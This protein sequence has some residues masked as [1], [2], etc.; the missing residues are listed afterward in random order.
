MR[1]KRTGERIDKVRASRDGHEF[2]EAWAAREALK[3]VMGN[4]GL[5]GIA[6]EGLAPGDYPSATSATVEIADLVLYYGGHPTFEDARSTV[7]VQIKYSKSQQET[8]YRASDAK[9]TI[10]KFAEAFRSHKKTH[11]KAKVEKKLTFELITNRPAY[12]DF[13]KAIEGLASGTVLR[14]EAKKQ[15]AQFTAATGFKAKELAQFAQRVTVTG[16]AGS[17]MHNKQRL[18]RSMVDW[19][20]APDAMARARLGNLKQLLRDKAGLAGQGKN[21]ITRI[22][23]L[24]AL[25]VQGPEDLFPCPESFPE[26]GVVVEREQLPVVAS[27]IPELRRPLLIHADGGAGKTVFLQSLAKLLGETHETVLFDCFG[28]GAYRA[29]DDARHLPKRGLIHIINNLAS[30]GLCDPLLPINQNVEEL[31]KA[32][33]VRLTQAVA[34]VRRWSG[35]KQLL[36][37]I[38]AIDNAAEHAN[39]TGQLSFPKLLLE[40]FHYNGPVA[41]VQLIV[42]CRTYRR[43]ISRGNIPCEEFEL[44]PF[45][46]TETENYL[47]DRIPEVTDTQIQVAFS[48]SEGNPRILEH[49][50]LG[51]RGLLDPSDVNLIITLNDLIEE[52]IQRALGEASKRGYKEAAINAFL[53]GLSVLPPPV[54]LDEYADAHG[55]DISAVKSFAADLAPLLE[56]TRHGLMFRDEPTETFV[57]NVYAANIDTLRL[58]AANLLQKQGTSVYAASTL[59][60]LLQKIDDGQ[61]LFEL[62]FD[63]RFPAAITSAVGKQNIRYARL[64][65]A[66]LH[67]ARKGDFDRLVHLLV[68]L[69]TLAAVNQRGTDYV[70][71]NPDLAV[72]SHD[73][74]AT[75]RLFETRTG[76]P[77]T[78]HARLAVA[79]ALA[80][81]LSDAY[82]HAVR[83]DEW[84][85]HFF[86]Q[87]DEYRRDKRGP[88]R[89]DIAAIP[90]CLVAQDRG[91]DAARLLDRWKDWYA[92]EVGEHVFTLLRQAEAMG[93]IPEQHIRRFLNSL[94]SQPGVLAAA[95]SSREF[96]NRSRR[97]LI[98]ILATACQETGKV[99]TSQDFQSE[100]SHVVEDG[101]LKAAA[102]AISLNMKPEAL[103]ILSA[104][105]LQRPGLWSLTDRYSSK[106]AFPFIACT[107]LRYAAEARRIPDHALLPEELFE[108]GAGVTDNSDGD[109]RARLMAE[110][111]RYFKSQQDTPDEKKGMSYDTKNR[112]ERFINERFQPLLEITLAFSTMVSSAAGKGDEAFVEL[113]GTWQKLRAKSDRYSDVHEFNPFF[114]ILGRE[115][116]IFALWARR[117]L[118][119]ASVKALVTKAAEDGIAPVSALIAITS[120]LSVRS[121]LHELAGTTAQKASSLIE[122][123]D[124][125]GQRASMFAQLSRSIMPA[126]IEETA[127]YFRSGLEQ[128]DAIGSGDYRFTNELLLFAGEL[129]GAEID[130]GDFHTLSNICELNMPSDEEKFPWLAFA[131]GMARV[132]GCR[133]LAKLGRWADRE[134]ISLD[135]T[136]LPYL[137]ALLKQDKM[138]P[139]IA[140]GLLRLS[141]PVELYECGTEHVAH[142]IAEKRYADA[143]Q[144]LTELISQFEHNHP[145]VF[146]ASTLKK[147]QEI[148][149][150][151]LGSDS[152]QIAYLSIAAPKFAKLRDDTNKNQQYGGVDD[153]EW[154]RK[155]KNQENANRRALQQ[156]AGET[157]PA[158]EESVS[159]AIDALNGMQ[160]VFDLKREFFANLRGRLKFAERSQ[161]VKIIANLASLDIYTK[162]GELKECKEKWGTSS[163][164]LDTVFRDL[165]IPLIQI[166]TDD[167]V[168]YD[169]FAGSQLQEVV[170]L[171]GRPIS[172]L[173]LE[174]IAIFS[175]ADSHVPAAVWMAFATLIAGKVTEGEGQIALKRLLNSGSAKLAST[176]VDGPWKDGLYPRNAATDIAAGLVWLSLGSPSAAQRW[177][178]AHSIRS[179]A[180]LGKWDVLDALME[181]IDST[182]ALPYQAP[183]LTFYFLHARLWLLIAIARAALDYP[184][185]VAKY[186]DALKA[187]A[188]DENLPHVLLRHFAAQALLNCDTGG[189]IVLSGTDANSLRTINRSPFPSKIITKH[190][191][192][193][194]YAAR[195]DSMPKPPVEFHLEYDFDKTDVTDVSD[196]FDTSR[197]ETK[198]A[199]TVWVRKY[200]SQITSMY[201]TGGR[202]RRSR[203]HLGMTARYHSYGEQLGWHTIYLVAG[204]FLRKYPVVQRPYSS[205]DPWQ[206]W[207]RNAQLTRTDGL[208]LADGV[209]RPPVEAQVNLYELINKKLVLTGDRAKI[210]AL[211][212]IELSM[213]GELVVAGDWTSADG[214]G[215]HISSALVPANNTRKLAVQLAREDPFQAWLPHTEQYDGTEE[216]CSSAKEPFK[217]W[218][219]WPSGE[220][221]LDET[222]PLGTNAAVRRLFLTRDINAIWSLTPKDPF[223]REW[224]D[225]D[226][227]VV[228][229]SEAWGRN[230]AHD[231]DESVSGQRLICSS[232]LLKQILVEQQAELVVLVVLR[233][234]NRSAGGGHGQYWHTTAVVRVDQSLNWEFVRGAVNKPHVMK[235]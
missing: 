150:R 75:R 70:L 110:V 54:P 92:Y 195:P 153:T 149:E 22:D 159:R 91:S 137:S 151:E 231:E 58:V 136:L 205:D 5:A 162:L 138:D 1:K 152:E 227:R 187:I 169:Y 20:A 4:D 185:S 199:M 118:G 104:I 78:R 8:P 166:H 46:L 192:G 220:A 72:A 49:L 154:R 207:L 10:G 35:E 39:D 57:R 174:F 216:Y 148:A 50:A 37:F 13:T 42:S 26:V 167:F 188:L 177:R 17:L 97:R 200:D 223:R 214:I 178:A 130:E 120:I 184:M 63:E 27:M 225:R 86:Q 112:A 201:E 87:D 186:A 176:V 24:D 182:D 62:A 74:D 73:V 40:S 48:R 25:E 193:S 38:D 103:A 208:W 132:S 163:A 95:L 102:A 84:I 79:S 210:L 60:G 165:A 83:A 156:I 2:H 107:A 98:R 11:G 161:Y 135:Y 90:V 108:L 82:R 18:S 133:T 29:P 69:S 221:R 183:E 114:D 19:S 30:D 198:D 106:Q 181:R 126:S 155:A 233:R 209:D 127:V 219:V 217:P 234:Y 45:T 101:L 94:R 175:A 206:E 68:E 76:W 61:L 41:G 145:G 89:L 99:E 117:D 105:P 31:V 96:D 226:G 202:V 123:E 59:P 232:V 52:R 100:R 179:L 128:M 139:R 51:A 160:H 6:V 53:A 66:V 196:M 143:K 146:M 124:E 228:V 71:D 65:A 172:E 32:F 28:G 164:A 222:D 33:R 93:S 142:V 235:Y 16:L 36:L 121:D 43:D 14:G 170:E 134:K 212:N 109:Y 125:I 47:R 111:E 215:I 21:V 189:G 67:S 80:G 191:Q 203:E 197:W 171:S 229:R 115:L 211:L 81:D 34:T 147:L 204:E 119:V 56:Q 122:R 230:R 158:L 213:P 190:A 224:S 180:Q 85:H 55:M 157:N 140:V 129:R 3:L 77:G 7:I 9:K 144:L 218:I 12:S 173:V 194:F 113:I 141:S 116:L 168:H 88:E 44:K 23:V 15:A 64:K 131:T